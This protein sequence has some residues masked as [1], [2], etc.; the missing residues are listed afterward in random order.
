MY[1]IQYIRYVNS[2]GSC[3]R[4]EDHRCRRNR[5]DCGWRRHYV[6]SI[7][8]SHNRGI[9]LME[10]TSFYFAILSLYIQSETPRFIESITLAVHAD[11]T[12]CGTTSS[13]K[14]FGV[15]TCIVQF[16][17]MRRITLQAKYW[18][19]CLWYL[20]DIRLMIIFHDYLRFLLFFYLLH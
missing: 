11:F 9:V 15:C 17:R 10:Q 6:E 14:N 7:S 20:L 18:L 13:W 2:C 8:S 16:W 3:I 4:A 12:L 5:M 19:L 1:D